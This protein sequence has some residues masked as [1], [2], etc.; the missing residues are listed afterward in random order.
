MN[1]APGSVHRYLEGGDN[2]LGRWRMHRS[3]VDQCTARELYEL[4]VQGDVLIRGWGAPRI[5]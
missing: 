2:P 1:V 4:A 5:Y 3:G